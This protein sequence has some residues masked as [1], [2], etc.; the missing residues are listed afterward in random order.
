MHEMQETSLVMGMMNK[1]SLRKRV[2]VVVID[3]VNSIIRF[4]TLRNILQERTSGTCG[5]TLAVLTS[6]IRVSR[7]L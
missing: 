6:I 5:S 7:S 4:L 2:A 3:N 1:G